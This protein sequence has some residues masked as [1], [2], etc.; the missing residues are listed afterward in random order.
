MKIKT[1]TAVFSL[2]GMISSISALDMYTAEKSILRLP[3]RVERDGRF[4][5]GLN[6]GYF[7]VFSG[8]SKL[9]VINCREFS[10]DAAGPGRELLVFFALT[11]YNSLLEGALQELVT[12]GMQE[13]DQLTLI[14]PRDTY[15][16]NAEALKKRP[17]T[18]V[19][20]ELRNTVR[21][22]IINSG[23]Q[24]KTLLN[25]LKRLSRSLRAQSGVGQGQTT[26]ELYDEF[27]DSQFGMESA[28]QRYQDTLTRIENMRL[29]DNRRLANLIRYA[30]RRGVPAS[31]Y[32]FHE[33]EYKPE[34]EAK[35]LTQM[36]ILFTDRPHIS[37]N[38]AMLFGLQQPQDSFDNRA[39][40]HL[41]ADNRAVFNVISVRSREQEGG[42][43]M[44]ESHGHLHE[45]FSALTVNSGGIYQVSGN[46]LSGMQEVVKTEA[47]GYLL[48]IAGPEDLEFL[49]VEVRLSAED[50]KLSYPRLIKK[51]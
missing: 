5:S 9:E 28:I 51:H 41:L 35:T 25:E 46:P 16:F 33:K 15:T 39:L 48:E 50:L 40:L 27:D 8:E 32:L 26:R 14:T 30:G 23:R 24:Y 13:T 7:S 43:D 17:I 36:M 38:L 45:V 18:S 2:L 6:C 34:I 42:L 44:S 21:R 22:D 47:N 11:D 19:I 12:N 1:M 3:V 37:H 29:L 31:L 20:E 4:V 49:Q 10:R